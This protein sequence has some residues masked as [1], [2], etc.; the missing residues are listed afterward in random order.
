[1]KKILYLVST[2]KR[3][4]PTNQLSYII[5]YLD[6]SKYTPTVLT[7][8]PEP[9][10]SMKSFFTED[11]GIEVNT[12][13]LSRIKG[14]FVAK[15]TILEFVRSNGIDL[16]HTQGIRA[17]A[18]ASHLNLSKVATIR[19]YPFYDY[20]MKFGKVKG[21]LMAR[22][23]FSVIRNEEDRFIACSKTISNEFSKNNINLKYIQNGV[24]TQRFMPVSIKAKLALREL[25]N[26]D[27]KKKIF[28]TVG[29][30]IS[31][32]D[33]ETLIKGF[34]L[35]NKNDSLLLIAGDGP[36]KESL[37]RLADESIIF[38]GNISNVVDYLQLSDCFISSSL[39]EGLPNT[40]LESMACGL[41]VLLSDIP[42]HLEIFNNE[43]GCFFPVKNHKELCS[44]LQHI[45][46]Q[47]DKQNKLSL[48]IVKNNFGA[49]LMSDKYQ[50]LYKELVSES[51]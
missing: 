49:N 20:P 13:G 24:D 48:K 18:L 19:N 23:H 36:E 4:G 6:R 5:K 32:K 44:G 34:L 46:S 25:Y 43:K 16:I 10:D 1:M 26:L 47:L 42:S 41:P 8:S 31:R 14:L 30:L 2:L 9:K 21:T 45:C 51:L 12:L 29:G 39:A 35:Y 7:L 27:S 22:K 15:S 37:K 50:S 33:T 17:D 38:L 11:L 40:V 28:I 3:S